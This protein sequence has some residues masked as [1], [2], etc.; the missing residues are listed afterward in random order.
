M[1]P[2]SI[3]RVFGTSRLKMVTGQYVDVYREAAAPGERRRYTKRFLNT[4][5]GDFSEWTEREWRI[6]ARL[7]GH[8]AH[9]VPDVVQYDR[10]AGGGEARVQ[11]YDAGVTLDHWVTLLQVQRDGRWQRHIF[12]DC[13]HW[14][15]L[16][17]HLLLAL[18][19]IHALQLVHLDLKADNICLPLLPTRFDPLQADGPIHPVFEDIALIDFAFSL[20]SGEALTKPLPIGWQR[21]FPYQSPRL[22]QALVAGHKGDLEPTRQLDW[23]CDM[24]SLAA[25]L[26]CLLP[27]LQELHDA[28]QKQ[29][30]NG[31]RHAAAQVLLLKIRETHD[32]EPERVL[33]HLSLAA[34][35][36]GQLQAADLA[37]S[38]RQGWTLWV[39]P[40]VD[41]DAMAP[42]APL[43]PVT[44]I[45]PPAS[46]GAPVTEIYVPGPHLQ[47][48]SADGQP[49]LDAVGSDAAAGPVAAQGET[50]PEES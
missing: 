2:A 38:L 46:A 24:Y 50:G 18:H 8:G 6:L 40:H 17:R 48:L 25:L 19:E 36:A 34:D 43:T 5:E 41:E 37:E 10:G 22:L 42:T 27:G 47:L 26:N 28:E 13:A 12:R 7:V 1:T 9:H 20:I 3:D 16:A 44:L 4:K 39:G 11:T 33:P 49:D 31:E 21:R 35:C 32:R 23:R 29:G 45:E 15:A 14:W 30:W